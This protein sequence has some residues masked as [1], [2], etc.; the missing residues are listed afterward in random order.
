M[1][2]SK[3]NQKPSINV[4]KKNKTNPIFVG[5]KM[6]LRKRIQKSDEKSILQRI[7]EDNDYGGK[8]K[9][10]IKTQKK[11]LFILII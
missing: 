10:R 4:H 11:Y 9:K 3:T 1:E 8:V 5:N 7:E 2:F 6:N